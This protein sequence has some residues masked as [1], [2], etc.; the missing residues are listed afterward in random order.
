M[1]EETELNNGLTNKSKLFV[2]VIEAKDLATENLISE[3]NPSVTLL[4]QD[5]VQETKIKNNTINPVWYEKFDFKINAPSGTLIIEVFDNP[6]V[7]KKS[8]G[9]LSIDLTDLM[10]QKKRTQWFDLYN[11]N[12]V[13]CGKIYLKIQCIVNF[14]KFYQTE[15]ENAEKEIAV[16]QNAYNL[17]NYNLDCMKFPFGLLFVENIDDLINNNPFQQA[18]DLINILEQKKE[19]I[20]TKRNN[21]LSEIKPTSNRR[22]EKGQKII[23][24]PLTKILMYCFIF[25]TLISLL[26]RSDFINLIIA[27]ITLNYFIFDKS[28]QIIKYLN[29]FTWLLG[30]TII[31]DLVWFFI[32]FGRFFIGEK[33]DPEKWL[34]RFTY[35][36]S[37]GGTV[38][39]CLFILAL[40]NIKKKKSIENEDS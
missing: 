34:K 12:N 27:I 3:C 21:D 32:Q 2:T 16:I 17:T 8:L 24:N 35:I 9:S 5:E 11:S 37:I 25:L 33:D 38:I 10:D 29:Y 31:I 7:G 20:Y 23:L 18:N 28:G 6:L 22:F 14:K 40:R 39:K 13:V 36:I 30:G 15:I 19:S 4:F 1:D 26:E